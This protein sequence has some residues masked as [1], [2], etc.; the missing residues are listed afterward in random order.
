MSDDLEHR[1]RDAGAGLPGPTA[2]DTAAARRSAIASLPQSP[3]RRRRLVPAL[4][5]A[6]LVGG[7]FGVGYAVAGSSTKVETRVVRAQLDAGPGFVP[8]EGWSTTT[9][10]AG[11]SASA[12]NASLGIRLD[13]TFRG[14]MLAAS[15]PQALLPLRLDE[16]TRV[17]DSTRRLHVR[18]A[19]W[20]IDV[21]VHFREQSQAALVAAREELGRLVVPLCPD[22]EELRDGDAA[23]AVSYVLGWL[24]SHYSDGDATETTGATAV[25]AAG[26]HAPR[27]GQ[28]AHYCGPVVAER[29]IEVDVTLPKLAQMSASLSQLTYFVARTPEG[30][31]VWA[32]AR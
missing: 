17:D 8:S 29:T 16:A 20:D 9:D 6:A 19:A 1:L 4:V 5:L 22:A 10:P 28:A 15:P 2:A 25:A 13:A 11:T 7:A 24:P 21:R 31:T 3:V 18:V 14:A 27:Y 32:R 30:W 26:T 12:V 23:V